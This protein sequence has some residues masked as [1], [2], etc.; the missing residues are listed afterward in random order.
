MT[1]SSLLSTAVIKKRADFE[2]EIF[3]TVLISRLESPAV[4][5]ETSSRYDSSANFTAVP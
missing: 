2:G 3:G 5:R 1:F 4:C